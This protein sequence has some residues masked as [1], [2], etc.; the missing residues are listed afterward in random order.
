MP[1]YHYRCQK[2]NKDFEIRHRYREQGIICKYCKSSEIKK[3]LGNAVS[4]IRKSNTSKDKK[5]GSEVKEAIIDGKNELMKTKKELTK[6]ARQ[7]ND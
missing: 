6:I 2:C 1:L 7:N 4:V 5:V 3:Y